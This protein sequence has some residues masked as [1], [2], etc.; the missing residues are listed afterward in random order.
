MDRKEMLDTYGDIEL[1]FTNWHK[2]L[3]K[4]EPLDKVKNP[5]L[6]VCFT[7]DYS[8]YLSMSKVYTIKQLTELDDHEYLMILDPKEVYYSKGEDIPISIYLEEYNCE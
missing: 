3:F 4:L 2:K 7:P 5:N 8:D 6:V 1:V